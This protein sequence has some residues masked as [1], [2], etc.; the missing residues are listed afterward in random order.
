MSTSGGCTEGVV[1]DATDVLVVLANPGERLILSGPTSLTLENTSLPRLTNPDYLDQRHRLMI[2]WEFR[3]HLFAELELYEQHALHD[4][5]AFSR[6]LFDD[7]AVLYRREVSKR[8][9]SLPQKAGRAY[10][11]FEAVVAADKLRREQE[12][13][14][15][16]TIPM[17][18]AT[19]PKKVVTVK[20]VARPELDVKRMV[21]ILY[22]AVAEDKKSGGELLND[23]K[24]KK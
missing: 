1:A 12:R 18:G 10:T 20:P 7:D 24:R 19:R 5:F 21:Q 8:W 11:H 22:R 2:A 17:R 23:S 4:F 14:K 13:E 6:E 16:T 9:P 3:P 15:V